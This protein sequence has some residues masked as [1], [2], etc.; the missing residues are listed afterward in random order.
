MKGCPGKDELCGGSQRA[1]MREQS[2]KIRT[3][4]TKPYTRERLEKFRA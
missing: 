2:E 1:A 4:N 3:P